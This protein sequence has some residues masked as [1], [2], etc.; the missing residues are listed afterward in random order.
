MNH[1]TMRKVITLTLFLAFAGKAY[2][3]DIKKLEVTE[4]PV[5]PCRLGEQ[6]VFLKENSGAGRAR[7]LK[8]EFQFRRISYSFDFESPSQTKFVALDHPQSGVRV[9]ETSASGS[10]I[11]IKGSQNITGAVFRQD[12]RALLTFGSDG[13]LSLVNMPAG[14]VVGSWSTTSKPVTSAAISPD[15]TKILSGHSDGSFEMTDAAGSPLRTFQRSEA[16]INAL[17]FSK[18]GKL[19]AIG[20]TLGQVEIWDLDRN[21]KVASIN[22]EVGAITALAF[23]ADSGSV[24]IAGSHRGAVL[25]NISTVSKTATFVGNSNIITSVAVDPR[26]EYLAFSAP[27][28]AVEIFSV[29]P[30]ALLHVVSRRGDFVAGAKFSDAG[31]QILTMLEDGSLIKIDLNGMHE[32]P[33]LGPAKFIGAA[34]AIMK[35]DLAE[36]GESIAVYSDIVSSTLKFSELKK[37]SDLLD[38]PVPQVIRSLVFSAD[39]ENILITSNVQTSLY[40]KKGESLVRLW[41]AGRYRAFPSFS[42]DG[43]WVVVSSADGIRVWS[44]QAGRIV[45]ESKSRSG[46]SSI[47]LSSST[48]IAASVPSG[49][50]LWNHVLDRE[51]FLPL[52]VQDLGRDHRVEIIANTVDSRRLAV[53][54]ID[55]QLTVLELISRKDE[56]SHLIDGQY[57]WPQFTAN[58]IGDVGRSLNLS[59]SPDGQRLAVH[60]YSGRIR[61]YKKTYDWL[62][63][64]T[65]PLGGNP[66]GGIRWLDNER[67]AK[68]TCVASA[69]ARSSHPTME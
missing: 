28:S 59:F 68:V 37:I 3:D 56:E 16:A 33:I 61:I 10:S 51:T 66:I 15:G 12:G 54:G 46:F 53:S 65:L 4:I 42:E 8:A 13:Q 24:I 44:L 5:G 69:S 36:M 30:P 34:A 50:R 6:N 67:L 35:D 21:M 2:A 52:P 9:W 22:A 29:H 38:G 31:D 48:V 11:F 25:W 60:S 17:A 23:S 27:S 57:V 39:G 63:E 32:Y 58:T 47:V 49:I 1:K 64:D 20:S 7:S 55:G 19:F 62:L 18:D 45:A 26:G 40:N 41:S 43:K 14:N